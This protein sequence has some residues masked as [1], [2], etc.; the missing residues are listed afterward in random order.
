MSADGRPKRVRLSGP[1]R[2]A[3][4]VAAAREVF[5]SEGYVGA[6]TRLIAE[7]AGINEAVL[8]QHFAGKDQ[9]FEV[10]ILEGIL[11]HVAALAD[12]MA[13][14]LDADA[15]S[16]ATDLLAAVEAAVVRGTKDL[17]PL[18]GVALFSGQRIGEAFYRDRFAPAMDQALAPVAERLGPHAGSLA[19]RTP[20]VLLAASLG[21]AMDSLFRDT[22]VPAARVGKQLAGVLEH[23]LAA[24]PRR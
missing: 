9:L 19:K 21:P 4:I 18:L 1:E 17:L 14:V 22:R 7:R 13:T 8:Y 6:R 16:S 23:G 12:E 24:P 10:A 11:D 5:L 3:G 20:A 15:D 2:R